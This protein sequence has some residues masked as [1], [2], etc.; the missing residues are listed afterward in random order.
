MNVVE[1]TRYHCMHGPARSRRAK[2]L[3]RPD[4]SDV[5][6][7]TLVADLWKQREREARERAERAERAC[8]RMEELLALVSHDLRTH[9][10]AVLNW[11]RV[12]G[13]SA[14]SPDAVRLAALHIERSVR[15]QSRLVH[16]L[17]D[18]ARVAFCKV[19]LDVE[20][21][22]VADLVEQ[23]L[24][25]IRHSAANKG[26][27]IAS[28]IPQPFE[29]RVDARRMQQVLV[30]LLM[31]AVRFTPSAGSVTVRAERDERDA[32]ISV[33]DTGCGIGHEVLPVIFERF[34]Q[35]DPGRSGGI[36]LGL[37]IVRTLV[38]L[39]GGS[40]TADSDGPGCGAVFTVRLPEVV[41]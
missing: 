24:S 30:N 28:V 4:A 19:E 2:L 17:F 23:S 26:V 35:A 40:V 1:N 29:L 38:D 25:L 37:H 8:E 6:T 15:Q 22:S 21:V 10:T 11:S 41:A 12:M 27:S 33:A 31:N 7:N 14:N 9:M 18:A 3:T 34:Q 13:G 5:T 32:V 36:G 20:T 16:D 39:H